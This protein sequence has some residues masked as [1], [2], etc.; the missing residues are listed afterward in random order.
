[1]AKIGI[2]LGSIR[3][4]RS[5]E[6][7]A[8]W[9]KEIADKR[10]SGVEYELLDLK[11]FNVPLLESAIVSGMANG[12]YDNA[13]VQAWADAIKSCDGFIFVTPEYNHSVPGA[14]KNAYDSL[15]AEWAGK[16]VAF[17]GYGASGA[18]RA[19]EAWRLVVSNFQMAQLR[20]QLEVSI[21]SDFTDGEFTPDEDKTKRMDNILAELE[22]AL[23]K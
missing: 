10:E 18:I 23:G 4:G 14:F 6:A 19:V 12:Q 9:V 13:N 8:N 15:G 20:N 5:G 16:P 7:I 22:D 1:M 2:I 3:E 17:V 21:F 11:S